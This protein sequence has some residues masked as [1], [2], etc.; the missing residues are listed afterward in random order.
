MRVSLD[1]AVVR[2]RAADGRVVGAG[3]LVGER[4]VL[5]CA[6]VVAGALGLPEDASE[7]QK[8]GFSEKTWF[9][10]DFPLVAPE[11]GLTARVVCWQ[12]AHPDGSGDVAGLELVDDPPAG[13]SPVR[14]VKTEEPWGHSFRAFGFPRGFDN[15]VWVSGRMLGRE[16]TGWV[17]IEDVKQ[18]GYF[19]QPGFSGSPVWDEVLSGVVGIVVTAERRPEV[20]VGFVIPTSTLILA[21]PEL[22]HI[23]DVSLAK[24]DVIAST[25]S[26]RQLVQLRNAVRDNQVDLLDV[27]GFEARLASLERDVRQFGNIEQLVIDKSR[28]TDELNRLLSSQLEWRSGAL[29][30]SVSILNQAPLPPSYFVG[31]EPLLQDIVNLIAASPN[32]RVFVASLHGFGGSGKTTIAKYIAHLPHVTRV[33]LDGVFWLDMGR[34]NT[35]ILLGLLLTSLGVNPVPDVERRILQTRTCTQEKRMLVIVDNALDPQSTKEL[36]DAIASG[37]VIITTRRRDVANLASHNEFYIDFF[38]EEESLTLFEKIV[39]VDFVRDS[40]NTVKTIAELCGNLP[41]AVE[42]SAKS[43][44]NTMTK[45]GWNV[46]DFIREL[47]ERTNLKLS[48]GDTSVPTIFEQSFRQLSTEEQEVFAAL[49]VFVHGEF[50]AKAV[51]AICELDLPLALEILERLVAFSLVQWG[52]NPT[53]YLLH[54]MVRS[55][56]LSLIRGGKMNKPEDLVRRELFDYYLEFVKPPLEYA[57][58][59]KDF[60]NAIS[61]IEYAYMDDK[62]VDS[63]A[64]CL[65]FADTLYDLVGYLNIRGYYSR[66][67]RLIRFGIAPCKKWDLKSKVSM[68]YSIAGDMQMSMGDYHKCSHDLELSEDFAME[69]NDEVT[70]ANT[71]VRRGTVY[72]NIG[73]YQKGEE[74]YCQSLALAKKNNLRDAELISYHHIGTVKS[75]Q[76]RYRESLTWL[77]KSEQLANSIADDIARGVSD[78]LNDYHSDETWLEHI[79]RVLLS[80]WVF[81]SL[82]YLGLG[83]FRIAQGYCMQASDLATSLEEKNWIANIGLVSAILALTEGDIEEAERILSKSLGL[84][85][86]VGNR[87]GESIALSRMA[88]VCLFQDRINDAI[89]R[90]NQSL[91][92]TRELNLRDW[93]AV[94]L[95]YLGI[96]NML[97]E[98]NDVGKFYLEESRKLFVNIAHEKALEVVDQYL[99]RIESGDLDLQDKLILELTGILLF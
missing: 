86:E 64:Q 16:A 2:V 49:G 26:P 36:I 40:E 94:N 39:G 21:W 9:L 89:S 84:F 92:M 6:H 67:L 68:L 35:H 30:K 10:L 79:K 71:K 37:V 20:K 88:S 57:A 82:A 15:G 27:L 55:Y 1:S 53:Y 12:P 13:A 73:E 76:M 91:D 45:P 29:P 96:L 85:Q 56:A 22:E 17:Q 4:R 44:R 66:G 46:E 61:A 81:T 42:I 70:L 58:I 23:A 19:V 34:S 43:I 31:R 65:D 95:F 3:F 72:V 93:Q 83:L 80:T 14:L 38:S 63:R 18:T 32:S 28:V 5:T 97:D 51:A 11:Q 87:Q 69:N 59:D 90:I 7:L 41:L 98:R 78:Y 74:L 99:G 25:L 62:V 47:E 60:E 48:N 8:P 75:K 33:F 50:S 24:L 52:G 77:F 54:P